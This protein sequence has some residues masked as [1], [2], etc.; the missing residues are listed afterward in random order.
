MAPLIKGGFC[1][2]TA[3]WSMADWGANAFLQ[4]EQIALSLS[5]FAPLEHASRRQQLVARQ[6]TCCNLR[7]LPTRLEL[8][9]ADLQMERL[10]CHIESPGAV[11]P[12]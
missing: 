1:A 12:A 5:L 4:A 8:E 2:V 7:M 9:Q 3:T 11:V 6:R 10:S